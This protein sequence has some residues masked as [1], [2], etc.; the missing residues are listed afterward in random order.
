[1][2][3][4]VAV[5]VARCLMHGQARVA[6]VAV[7]QPAAVVALQRRRIAAPIEEYQRLIAFV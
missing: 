6:V 2:I 1:M 3:A 5:Q 7:G 4:V